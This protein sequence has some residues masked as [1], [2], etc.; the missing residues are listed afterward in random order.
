MPVPETGQK[1]RGLACRIC[2][3]KFILYVRYQDYASDIGNKD[4]LINQ[5]TDHLNMTNREIKQKMM[6]LSKLQNELSLE[7]SRFT[8]FEF[9]HKQRMLEAEMQLDNVESEIE[10]MHMLINSRERDLEFKTL[11]CDHARA[12]LLQSA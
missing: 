8:T 6:G 4:Q 9:Q 5:N 2:D 7:Q 10:N 11:E 12:E 1:L 3:R